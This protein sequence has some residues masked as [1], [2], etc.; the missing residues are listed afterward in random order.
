M[1]Y[2]V[3]DM[4]GK[5]LAAALRDKLPRYMLPNIVN[6]LGTMPLT[7]NGKLDRVL[8]KKKYEESK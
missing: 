2:F 8:L 1:L 5:A 7:P 6:K 3:G 4:E